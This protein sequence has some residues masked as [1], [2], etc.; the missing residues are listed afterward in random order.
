MCTVLP[1]HTPPA[2]VLLFL[3][4]RRKKQN[5]FRTSRNLSQFLFQFGD[6]LENISNPAFFALVGSS[7]TWTTRHNDF[8]VRV[9]IRQSFK[10]RLSVHDL[11][12]STPVPSPSQPIHRSPSNPHSQAG[13]TRGSI[14][15]ADAYTTRKNR[16]SKYKN[17]EQPLA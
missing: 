9:S 1:R 12:R 15:M 17:L 3:N 10:F 13:T 11:A 16:N 2:E 8:V 5:S 14:S 6:Y 7:N 4:W